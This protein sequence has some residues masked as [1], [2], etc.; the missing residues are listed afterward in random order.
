[1]LQT[2]LKVTYAVVKS[3][4]AAQETWIGERSTQPS[5]I[6]VRLRVDCYVY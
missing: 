3:L 2:V 4:R 1:M 5:L 6:A